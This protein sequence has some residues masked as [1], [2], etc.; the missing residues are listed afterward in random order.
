M[1]RT[2]SA[3]PLLKPM[4]LEMLPQEEGIQVDI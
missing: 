3:L 4:Y 2:G 1:E